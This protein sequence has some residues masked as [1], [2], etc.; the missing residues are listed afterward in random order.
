MAPSKNAGGKSKVINIIVLSL[1]LNFIWLNCLISK[2]II[3][4]FLLNKFTQQLEQVTLTK[5]IIIQ[6]GL[7]DTNF[8]IYSPYQSCT[9]NTKEC[10]KTI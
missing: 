7:T 6:I 3:L 4:L 8:N 2:K 9:D 1:K 5:T 10:Y